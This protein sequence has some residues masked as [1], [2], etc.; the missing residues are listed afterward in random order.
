MC[1]VS[2]RRCLTA[3]HLDLGVPIWSWAPKGL[4]EALIWPYGLIYLTF[5][6]LSKGV[7]KNH[8]STLEGVGGLLKNADAATVKGVLR[9]K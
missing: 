8:I 3:P 2:E 6:N 9:S 1:K 7:L 5:E 4:R